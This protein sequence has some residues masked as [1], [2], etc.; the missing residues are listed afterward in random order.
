MGKMPGAKVKRQSGIGVEPVSI[1]RRASKAGAAKGGNQQEFRST[2]KT[3][4]RFF[5]GKMGKEPSVGLF[6]AGKWPWESFFLPFSV[7]NELRNHRFAC[8]SV[9]K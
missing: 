8:F 2:I 4:G 1:P 9:E 6:F 3:R 5:G 7:M